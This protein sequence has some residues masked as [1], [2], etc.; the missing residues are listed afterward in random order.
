MPKVGVRDLQRDASG[1]IAR[2]MRTGRPTIVTKHNEPVA[3]VVAIDPGELEDFVLANA[4]EFVRSMRGADLA[5]LEGRTRSA[6]VVFEEIEAEPTPPEDAREPHPSLLTERE[7]EVL[8]LVADG[9]T[10]RDVA[11]RLGVTPRTV[12]RTLARAFDKLHIGV[13]RAGART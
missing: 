8:G 1:V 7:R 12:E 5:L 13:R 9:F 4:P 6:D 3:A 11:E 10:N 2:V